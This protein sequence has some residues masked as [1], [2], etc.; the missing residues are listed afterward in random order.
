MEKIERYVFAILPHIWT[1][2]LGV[3]LT[4]WLL[5]KTSHLYWEGIVMVVAGVFI[6]LDIRERL[7][8][9]SEVQKR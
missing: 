3:M 5:T 8:E 6:F 9:T 2:V 1:F 7:N 4:T